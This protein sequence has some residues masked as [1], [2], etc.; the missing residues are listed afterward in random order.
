MEAKWRTEE[1]FIRRMCK[2][3]VGGVIYTFKYGR[4]ITVW[5]EKDNSWIRVY[6]YG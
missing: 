3:F 5:R 6:I 4:G 1:K 2:G